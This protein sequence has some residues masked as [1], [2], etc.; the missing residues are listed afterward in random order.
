MSS[1]HEHLTS[2]AFSFAILPLVAA[3]TAFWLLFPRTIQ[4]SGKEL[5][6]EMVL[7]DR[8]GSFVEDGHGDRRR[9]LA[10][11]I[12][13]LLGKTHDAPDMGL[14]FSPLFAGMEDCLQAVPDAP[15]G[16]SFSGGCTAA[17]PL[18]GLLSI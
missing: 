8:P 12:A 13:D 14:Q 11:G 4:L 2:T 9:S 6:D 18:V 15:C 10:Q 17:A 1:E 7:A 3:D 5:H 16:A